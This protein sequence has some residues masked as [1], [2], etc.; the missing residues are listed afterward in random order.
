M[1]FNKKITKETLFSDIMDNPELIEILLES[2]MHCIGCP[3]SSQETIEQGAIAHGIN[4]ETLI[5]KLNKKI[6][7][8]K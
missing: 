2:G 8:E 3:M 4:P 5:N 1:T 6:Q 7:N